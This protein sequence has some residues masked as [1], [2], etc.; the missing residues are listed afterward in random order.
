MT[1]DSLR[2]AS[3]QEFGNLRVDRPMN[4]DDVPLLDLAWAKLLSRAQSVPRAS[5]SRFGSSSVMASEEASPPRVAV[6][7]ISRVCPARSF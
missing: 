1:V 2:D 6:P 3:S 4:C 5:A 7:S